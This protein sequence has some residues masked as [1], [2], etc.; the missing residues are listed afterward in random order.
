MNRWILTDEIRNRIKPL[1]VEWFDFVE[2][3][4][5]EQLEKVELSETIEIDLSD[6]GIN[7]YQLEKLLEEFG[8][9]VDD[10]DDNGWERDFWIYMTRKDGKNFPSGCEN[11]AIMCCGMTFELKVYIQ[12]EY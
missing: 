5:Y 4:T 1:L 11:I 6:N 7:P 10:R 3:L 2:S 9:E 12:D 8:Y